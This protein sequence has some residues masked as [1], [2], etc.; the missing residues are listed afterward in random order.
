[1]AR[2]ILY[3]PVQFDAYMRKYIPGSPPM[4]TA[5]GKQA[6]RGWR[7]LALPPEVNGHIC[8]YRMMQIHD[9]VVFRMPIAHG[10]CG[11]RLPCRT[12]IPSIRR[13][14][15]IVAQSDNAPLSRRWRSFDLNHWCDAAA[16]IYAHDLIV[17]NMFFL[18]I[19]VRYDHL[20]RHAYQ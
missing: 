1:M 15:H 8:T 5:Y 13:S 11:V 4:N 20:R 3:Y 7:G 2:C 9:S 18:V 16:V 17:R 19:P 10:D 14:N 6:S 12:T